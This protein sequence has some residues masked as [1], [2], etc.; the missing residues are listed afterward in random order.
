MTLLEDVCKAD[1]IKSIG[2]PVD[3][4]CS[5]TLGVNDT[6]GDTLAVEVR[7]QI[8]QVVVLEKKRPVLADT[9]GLIRVRHGNAI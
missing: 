3:T 7:E 1:I 6:L 8:D 9:L 4:V 5:T 2:G